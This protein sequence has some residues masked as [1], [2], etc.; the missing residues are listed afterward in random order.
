[1]DM[2]LPLDP[3]NLGFL[4]EVGYTSDMPVDEKLTVATYANDTGILLS[5]SECGLLQGS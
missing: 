5:L 1:M 3:L 4:R 2:I